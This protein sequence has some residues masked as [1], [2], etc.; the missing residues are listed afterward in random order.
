MGGLC[1]YLDQTGTSKRL[2]GRDLVTDKDH[3][4][5]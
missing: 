3:A 5:A 2:F 1:K 4:F